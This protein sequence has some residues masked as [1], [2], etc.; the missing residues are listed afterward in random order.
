MISYPLIVQNQNMMEGVENILII[1]SCC[2]FLIMN[3][4]TWFRMM[5]GLENILIIIICCEI[6]IMN[7]NIYGLG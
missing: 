6:L 5:E 3:N 1:I 7:N 2:E 4:N